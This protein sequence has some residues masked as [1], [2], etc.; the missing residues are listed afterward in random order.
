M[1]DKVNDLRAKLMAA[2]GVDFRSEETANEEAADQKDLSANVMNELSQILVEFNKL[3]VEDDEELEPRIFGLYEGFKMIRDAHSRLLVRAENQFSKQLVIELIDA[4]ENMQKVF[5]G[6]E[7]ET[8][9]VI[10]D[11]LS[12]FKN[13]AARMTTALKNGGVAKIEALGLK[14]DPS[15]HK[16]VAEVKNNDVE[17]QT[18][19]EEASAGY[20]FN[21]VVIKPA[22]VIISKKVEKKGRFRLWKK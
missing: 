14:F 4:L 10:V 21:G 1:G 7:N 3:F 18:V 17:E 5:K 11:I 8:D 9:Q 6:Y 15:V 16:A 19:V 2:S 22:V 13:V 20:T 12:G